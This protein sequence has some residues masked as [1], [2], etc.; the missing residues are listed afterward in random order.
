MVLFGKA[1]WVTVVT[2]LPNSVTKGQKEQSVRWSGYG[3]IWS[4]TCQSRVNETNVLFQES[5]KVSLFFWYLLILELVNWSKYW[6]CICFKV[7]LQVGL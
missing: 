7:T 6:L 3:M 5:N 1:G 4:H 2:D